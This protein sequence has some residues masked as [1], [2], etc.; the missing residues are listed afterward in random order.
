MIFVGG[1]SA[2]ADDLQP[3]ADFHISDRLKARRL[4]ETGE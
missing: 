4:A 2:I 1:M 3:L